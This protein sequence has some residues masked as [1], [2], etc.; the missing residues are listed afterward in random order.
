MVMA[1]PC[2]EYTKN[3]WAV[4]FQWKNSVICEL[5][6]NFKVDEINHRK[7]YEGKQ[8][9]SLDR[10]LKSKDVSEMGEEEPTVETRQRKLKRQGERLLSGVC[11]N[12]LLGV[13]WSLNHAVLFVTPWTVAHQVPLSVEF[14]R[15]EYW[16]GLPFPPPGDLSNPGIESGSPTWQADSYHVSHSWESQLLN[17]KER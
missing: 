1:T 2:Y 12:Q 3:Q 13:W 17:A 14:S 8:Q 5:Y 15:Q 4:H 11:R 9:E 7:M 16:S 6:I 10:P